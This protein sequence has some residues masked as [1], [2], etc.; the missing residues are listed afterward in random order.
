MAHGYDHHP[1]QTFN[2]YINRNEISRL[3]IKWQFSSESFQGLTVFF[4]TNTFLKIAKT[5]ILRMELRIL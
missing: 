4:K 5:L 3:L 2:H 1:R